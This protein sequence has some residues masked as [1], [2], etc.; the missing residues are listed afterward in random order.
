MEYRPVVT[1]HAPRDCKPLFTCLQILGYA[2]VA[3]GRDLDQ[4]CCNF[5]LSVLIRLAGFCRLMLASANL[6]R[7]LVSEPTLEG[8]G[9]Q[10]FLKKLSCPFVYSETTTMA[11]QPYSSLSSRRVSLMLFDLQ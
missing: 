11:S 10:V 3:A 9:C 8:F 2:L 7:L 1:T 4:A 5:L 6:V